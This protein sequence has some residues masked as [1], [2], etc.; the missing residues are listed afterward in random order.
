MKSQT[1]TLSALTCSLLTALSVISPKVSLGNPDKGVECLTALQYGRLSDV[2]RLLGTLTPEQQ[3]G[4]PDFLYVTGICADEGLGQKIDFKL[5]YRCY[6]KADEIGSLRARAARILMIFFGQGVARDVNLARNLYE[7]SRD[8]FE[9]RA[10]GGD[11]FLLYYMSSFRKL[12]NDDEK[13]R[14]ENLRQS[15]AK[16]FFL[17]RLILDIEDFLKDTSQPDAVRTLEKASANGFW[18]ADWA[19]LAAL[20]DGD[21]PLHAGADACYA[22]C[23]Q[24]LAVVGNTAS[25]AAAA[26]LLY[27]CADAGI[28]CKSDPAVALQWLQIAAR[29]GEPAAQYELGR[30]LFVGNGVA[31]D[32]AAAVSWFRKASE[33]GVVFADL[34]LAACLSCGFGVPVDID[35]A[36]RHYERA[37]PFLDKL[38]RD[39]ANDA[40]DAVAN[41]AAAGDGNNAN[42]NSPPPPMPASA[43]GRQNVEMILDEYA[44]TGQV[45]PHAS[46]LLKI[47]QSGTCYDAYCLGMHFGKRNRL[48]D[49]LE[50][51]DLAERRRVAE[52]NAG[53][54]DD[55][56]PT[57]QAIANARQLCVM[58]L[59]QA[60]ANMRSVAARRA[61]REARRASKAE[62]R[63][64]KFCNA[65]DNVHGLHGWYRGRRC[66]ACSAP[67]FPGTTRVRVD[68]SRFRKSRR[69]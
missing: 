49:A 52:I 14:Q 41:D 68:E 45:V 64:E 27:R 26:F 31:R 69:R 66:P 22:N 2:H 62:Q 48:K 42:G 51:F 10:R 9:R 38:A 16:G 65:C 35:A 15:A 36:R 24:N 23:C 13:G 57:Q 12:F 17:P 50:S 46:L 40:A 1:Q 47:Q 37:K 43:A 5:A 58:G 54:K 32:Q 21:D 67:Q 55:F 53:I 7:K 60:Q 3:S 28:G 11:P 29:N 34:M 8:E 25:G 61:G 19:R 39:A 63:R 6:A 56:R 59:G 4:N 18:Q 33:Q 20:V 44:R 30:R